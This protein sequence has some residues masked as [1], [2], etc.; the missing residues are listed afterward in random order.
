MSDLQTVAYARKG[1]IGVLTP[2]ANTTVEPE[3]S[4][5][6]PEGYAFINARMTSKKDTIEER[7]IDYAD[8]I[9]DHIAQF[10]NAPIQAVALAT[11]GASYL[12]GKSAED[13]LIERVMKSWGLPLVTTALA[14]CDALEVLNARRIALISPYPPALTDESVRYWQSRDLE[15]ARV[16]SAFE[17]GE[18]FHPIYA[19]AADAAGAGLPSVKNCGADAIL[20]LGTGMPTLPA[21]ATHA[22]W[23]GPPILSCMLALVWRSV[24]AS[25][26]QK[27]GTSGLMDWITAR[28]WRLRIG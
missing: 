26:G 24:L 7:L 2:Q 15:V 22:H 14:V 28:H 23:D 20:M 13:A 10:A 6:C 25:S 18:G 17:D 11:T 21:I 12:I 16:V 19:L 9:E 27:L 1:L 8:S 3:Y 5:L 4:I